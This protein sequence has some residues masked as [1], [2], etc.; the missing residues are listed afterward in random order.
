MRPRNPVL[1]TTDKSLA[2]K[3]TMESGCSAIRDLELAPSFYLSPKQYR[4]ALCWAQGRGVIISV[5]HQVWQWNG[6]I[7]YAALSLR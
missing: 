1:I 7:T 4:M 6:K 3:I 5:P 2:P